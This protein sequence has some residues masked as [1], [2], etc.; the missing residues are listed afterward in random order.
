MYGKTHDKLWQIYTVGKDRLSRE[1]DLIN[2]AKDMRNIKIDLRT[3]GL[4]GHR[5]LRIKNSAKNI[6]EVDSELTEV[7]SLSYD[8]YNFPEIESEEPSSKDS[9]KQVDLQTLKDEINNNSEIDKKEN[10]K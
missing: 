9:E 6:I 2:I 8:E 5:K 3:R 7:E 1:L 10:N 4:N